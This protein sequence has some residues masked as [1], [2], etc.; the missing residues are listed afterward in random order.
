MRE[1]FAFGLDF[2]LAER[3]EFDYRDIFCFCRACVPYEVPI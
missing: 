2:K 1:K 3:T